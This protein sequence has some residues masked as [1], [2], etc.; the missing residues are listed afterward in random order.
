MDEIILKL[1][2]ENGRVIVPDFGALIVKQKTPFTVIFNEFLQY[3]DGALV[4]AVASSLNIE[5]D[6]ASAKVRDMTKELQ[7]KLKNN[8]E[9]MLSGI[10]VLS[11]SSTG[12]ISLRNSGTSAPPPPPQKTEPKE[13][14]KTVEFDMEEKPLPKPPAEE[15]PETRIPPPIPEKAKT[16]PSPAPRNEAPKATPTPAPTPKQ[17]SSTPSQETKK[18]STV[19]KEPSKSTSTETTPITEYYAERGGKKRLNLILWIVIILIVNGAIVSFFLFGDEIRA[20]LGK[21]NTEVIAETETQSGTNEENTTEETTNAESE[22]TTSPG[23]EAETTP[24]SSTNAEVS[25]PVIEE[26]EEETPA[27]PE[28]ERQV[29]AGTK[30]YVVAGVFREESN[31]DN[32]VLDLKRKGYNAEKFG[33]IGR[34]HAV[35]YDVFPSKQEADRLMMKIKRDV[36]PNAWVKIVD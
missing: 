12:K 3:N 18:P 25:E 7:E 10:G 35:S 4:G 9:V 8:Q 17:A 14:S 19:S 21:G 11:K 2:K 26:A 31:A 22:E 23:T 1:L 29:F 20:M 13:T 27:P 32:L 33:K 6:A 34:M 28:P 36:D 16:P 15:K 30:Y 24:G 5:R